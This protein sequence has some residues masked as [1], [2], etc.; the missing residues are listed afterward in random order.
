MCGYQHYFKKYKNQGL[1]GTLHLSIGVKDIVLG[2]MPHIYGI[3]LSM[4]SIQ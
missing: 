3:F 4:K 1:R 2:L